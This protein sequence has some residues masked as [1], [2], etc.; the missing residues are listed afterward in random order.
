MNEDD[1]PMRST[2]KHWS[3]IYFTFIENRSIISAYCC[4]SSKEIRIKNIIVKTYK[5]YFYTTIK[6][7]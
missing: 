3:M 2:V 6:F 5:M 4:H 7:L 1:E